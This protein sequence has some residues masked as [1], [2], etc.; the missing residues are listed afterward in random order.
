MS[1]GSSSHKV[2]AK[3]PAENVCIASTPKFKRRRVS[4]VQ[5]FPP[6]CGRVTAPSSRSSD[7]AC[8]YLV[9]YVIRCVSV[10]TVLIVDRLKS[11]KCV[12]RTILI[13]DR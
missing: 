9:L 1:K 11:R 4:A 12:S 3:V 7:G 13:V 8:E 6:G 2:M 10:Y 5:D